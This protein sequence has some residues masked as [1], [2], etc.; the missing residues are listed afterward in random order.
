MT[1]RSQP[2]RVVHDA[3]GHPPPL[4][5][6]G[7]RRGGQRRHHDLAVLARRDRR[8]P[9][10]TSVES[11]R[12]SARRDAAA[13]GRHARTARI[14]S[15]C[16]SARSSTGVTC[17]IS[18][19]P[20]GRLRGAIRAR[21]SRSSATTGPSARGHRGA[22][23][24]PCARWPGALATLGGRGGARALYGAARAFAFLSEYEGLG[25]TP[26]EALAVRRAATALD[27]PVA[28]ESCGRGGALCGAGDLRARRTRSSSCSST[29][30]RGRPP[31]RGAGCPRAVQL[32]PRRTGHA[33]RHR[34]RRVIMP[35][36]SIIIVSYNARVRSRAL[37]R[38]AVHR[39]AAA[40][41]E[42]IVVDNG[43]SDGSVEAA[44]R[45]PGVRV[46]DSARTVAS[47]RPTI[48]ESAR[49]PATACCC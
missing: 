16:S 35:T 49:A 12:H 24:A 30:P 46:I 19:A 45:L 10:R 11:P 9:R 34:A 21:C 15:C 42:I 13:H 28:R 40:S 18:S 29:R 44:R 43:S 5:V 25:L 2:T 6:P 27:T 8:A 20:S 31:R 41:H 22:A 33:G 32:A 38:V 1:C 48:S 39:P 23:R 47:R 36:L 26:L 7:S 37:P 17:R 14:R 4:A 3:R